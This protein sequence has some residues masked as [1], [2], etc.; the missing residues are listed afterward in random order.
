MTGSAEASTFSNGTDQ[1]LTNTAVLNAGGNIIYFD[2]NSNS[3]DKSLAPVSSQDTTVNALSTAFTVMEEFLSVTKKPHVQPSSTM[4]ESQTLPP[5]SASLQ[6][7]ISSVS[8]ESAGLDGLDEF[9]SDSATRCNTEERSVRDI[10]TTPSHESEFCPSLKCGPSSCE[11]Y[12]DKMFPLKHGY[13]LWLPQPDHSLP[14]E[15]CRKGVSI[16]DVGFITCDGSFDF[17]FNIWNPGVEYSINRNDL[18][19]GF[20]SLVSPPQ[21]QTSTKTVFP[22]RSMIAS[23]SNIDYEVDLQTMSI[24]YSYHDKEPGAILCMPQGASR[25]DCKNEKILKGFI[26]RSAESWYRYALKSGRDIDRHSLYLVTGTLKSRTWG[27]VTY[28]TAAPER[29]STVVL[30]KSP[31]PEGPVYE[32][33][34]TG[35]ATTF[36]TGPV[37]DATTDTQSRLPDSANQCLFLR[38]FKISLSEKAWKQIDVQDSILN[39]HGKRPADSDHSYDSRKG[40]RFRSADTE[41]SAPANDSETTSNLK[42]NNSVGIKKF[43]IK[44]NPSHPLNNIN[45]MLLSRVSG[46]RVAITHDSEW[47]E[48]VGLSGAE[49]VKLGYSSATEDIHQKIQS[50][51]VIGYDIGNETCTL[52]LRAEAKL[53]QMEKNEA[54]VASSDM[55]MPPQVTLKY[56]IPCTSHNHEEDIPSS[57]AKTLVE[58][59]STQEWSSKKELKQLNGL[60][61]ILQPDFGA[62]PDPGLGYLNDTAPDSWISSCADI[63]EEFLFQESSKILSGSDFISWESTLSPSLD[64]SYSNTA[65]LSPCPGLSYSNNTTPA[66]SPAYNLNIT[67]VPS[68][69]Y[70][71]NTTPVPQPALQPAYNRR[72]T[73]KPDSSA[74]NPSP[75]S[76]HHLWPEYNYD[77]GIA[78]HHQFDILGRSPWKYP[79]SFEEAKKGIN[80]TTGPSTSEIS[81]YNMINVG[82]HIM[83]PLQQEVSATEV[84]TSVL[85][86]LDGSS[87]MGRS[88]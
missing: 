8:P 40:K 60:R 4:P 31:D 61:G 83:S 41:H 59:H 63:F 85:A 62:A 44:Q 28:D 35:K 33:I 15:Y 34:K 5:A 74:D 79:Y 64:L 20:S 80:T 48:V 25:E 36:R 55:E 73:P 11:V 54:S 76:H 14:I 72:S 57:S 52:E 10:S 66:P 71:F 12:A 86:V 24:S 47:F 27:I 39:E 49:D 38:G 45:D 67:P 9:C 82:H 84:D 26:G 32:W 7:D 22:P 29:F 81:K 88:L 1:T 43:P 6:V 78:N 2:W 87:K 70:N 69:A 23:N 21:L 19:D 42:E 51:F 16:G 13:P 17:L 75:H 30:G 46:S 56:T 58:Q 3:G 53:G 37:P 18:A 50:H 68:P 65:T 77:G